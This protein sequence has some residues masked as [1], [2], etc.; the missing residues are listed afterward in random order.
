MDEMQML[1]ALVCGAWSEC[2]GLVCLELIHRAGVSCGLHWVH[3]RWLT[4]GGI[5]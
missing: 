1:W 3:G 5:K 4:G 2:N